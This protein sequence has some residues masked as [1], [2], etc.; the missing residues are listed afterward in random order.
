MY[1]KHIALL[2]TLSCL[3]ASSTVAAQPQPVEKEQGFLSMG[4][5]AFIPLGSFENIALPSAGLDLTGGYWLSDTLSAVMSFDY[6]YI[7]KQD[8]LSSSINLSVYG[9]GMGLRLRPP[10]QRSLRPF[11]EGLMGI[12]TLR[13]ASN[14]V[15]VS[16]SGILV[17]MA[18]GATVTL[19]PTLELGA[20]AGYR[21]GLS[22]EEGVEDVGGLA[23]QGF[24]SL[25][26]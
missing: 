11:V 15:V 26:F 10:S 20:K 4:P 9:F 8:S 24:L 12:H 14:G 1:A 13:A 18:A 2:V 7:T 22:T 16:E 23:V 3:G 5:L 6:A 19:S 21:H 25:Q 17:R